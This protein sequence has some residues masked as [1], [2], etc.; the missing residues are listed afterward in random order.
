[1]CHWDKLYTHIQVLFMKKIM[2]I[3][4]GG[5]SKHAN[6]DFLSYQTSKTI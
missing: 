1:M 4:A 6:N 3:D 2:F 5:T